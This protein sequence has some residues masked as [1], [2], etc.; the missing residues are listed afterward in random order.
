M[1]ILVVEDETRI[2]S[3]IEKGLVAEGYPCLVAPDAQSALAA[4]RAEAVDLV[5]L[6][7][8]LPDASGLD[9]LAS[10]R[11][12]DPRL[13]VLVLS[14]LDDVSARVRGLEAGADDYLGKPFDFM[15]LLARIRALLRRDQATAIEV[16]A[17]ELEL[18]LRK[19][20]ARS[21]E[22]EVEL[23]VR[24]SALLEHFLRHPNQVLTRAQLATGV[25]PYEAVGE[26]NVVDVYI[27]YLRRRVPWPEGIRLETVRGAG[28]RLRVV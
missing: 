6:D 12:S 13:P 28:Y 27:G 4:V 24:E 8:V 25:W 17:G 9:V 5:V 15:E 2:A 16:R 21:A 20:A 7:L 19:R 18:D 10:I 1:L 22:S 23:T 26:S 11:R 3:F 14:A